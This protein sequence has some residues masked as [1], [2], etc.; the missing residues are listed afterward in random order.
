MLGQAGLGR[1]GLGQAELGQAGLGVDFQA[2][3]AGPGRELVPARLG[4]LLQA[5]PGGSAYSE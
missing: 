1:L 3:L 2:R 4:V 5:S